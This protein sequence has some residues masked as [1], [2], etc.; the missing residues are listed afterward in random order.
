MDVTA[1][2]TIKTV[3]HMDLNIGEKEPLS[4]SSGILEFQ[5]L[6]RV[7]SDVPLKRLGCIELRAERTKVSPT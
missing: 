5:R 4:V 2:S 7:L 3:S 1:Y 6:F